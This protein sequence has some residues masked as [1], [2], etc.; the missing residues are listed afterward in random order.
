MKL[1]NPHPPGCF[2]H[3]MAETYGA[4]DI[5]YCE[6]TLCAFI[7]EPA[8]TWSNMAFVIVGL[9]IILNFKRLTQNQDSNS[10]SPALKVYGLNMIS[11]GLTSFFYHLSNNFLTQF[12]DFLGMYAFGG[13][14]MFYHLEQLGKLKSQSLIRN[15]LLSFIPFTLIFF[16]LRAL[17][18]PVQF[19]VITVALIVLAT[20]IKLVKIYRPKFK[21]FFYTL[22]PFALAVTS[23]ILDINRVACNPQNHIFQF[24]ALW[25]IFNALGMGMLFLYY[26]NFH[27]TVMKRKETV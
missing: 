21:L 1:L 19:S 3:E 7:S 5:K 17:Q 26:L 12:F 14:L 16:A 27:K 23:Q 10:L 13:L 6:E 18:L 22:I 15:Y 8:N 24:H 11:V 9:L 25:H 20:K 4:P 2:W